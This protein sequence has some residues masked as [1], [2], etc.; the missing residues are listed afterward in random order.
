MKPFVEIFHALEMR[1][2]SLEKEARGSKI[3][4][5]I[6]GE[7]GDSYESVSLK[8]F[9]KLAKGGNFEFKDYGEGIKITTKAYLDWEKDIDWDYPEDID[10]ESFDG[11]ERFEISL[12]D[13]CTAL[14]TSI[15]AKEKY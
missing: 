8:K 10:W 7:Y 13:L 3:D 12:N 15:G 11:I 2:A 6:P 14:L 1:V 5:R 9:V 4:I